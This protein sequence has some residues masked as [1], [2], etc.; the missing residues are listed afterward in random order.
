MLYNVMYIWVYFYCF[1]FLFYYLF[2]NIDIVYC[3]ATVLWLLWHRHFPVCR[4]NKGILSLVLMYNNVT[5][6]IYSSSIFNSIFF[7]LLNP[8]SVCDDLYK[9][10]LCTLIIN[11]LQSLSLHF[12]T[13]RWRHTVGE[14][15]C[16]VIDGASDTDVTDVS[17]SFLVNGSAQHADCWGKSE[18]RARREQA[19]WLCMFLSSSTAHKY[20]VNDRL[21]SWNLHV[22]SP[23]LRVRASDMC[24]AQHLL[25]C[26]RFMHLLWF[27]IP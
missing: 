7:I 11:V 10:M 8:K 16:S 15:L 9:Y 26:L 27:M 22:S 21:S 18:R 6:H 2:F 23:K 3:N 17:L 24:L 13:T 25:R 14:C 4:T 19:A 12:Y 1:Y 20:C 5:Y